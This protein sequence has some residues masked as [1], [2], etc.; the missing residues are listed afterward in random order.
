M[1]NSGVDA[2]F[3]ETKEYHRFKEFC[4][5][6][7]QY[8][9]IGLCYGV[10]GIGKTVSARYYTNLGKVRPVTPYPPSEGRLEKG[11]SKKVALYT[12]SVVNSPGQ[13]ARDM[14]KCR[15][16]FSTNMLNHYQKEEK[17]KLEEMGR[18]LDRMRDAAFRDGVHV[19]RTSTRKSIA[20]RGMPTSPHGRIT[21]PAA[22]KFGRQRF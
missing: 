19:Q 20:M 10:P 11:L 13:I 4:D 15:D 12:P 9:Y 18:N 8:Q 3:I 21:S 16:N 7:R 14:G 5:A 17:P 1:T 2:E 6:C 22:A